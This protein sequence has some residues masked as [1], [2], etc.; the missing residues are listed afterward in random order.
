MILSKSL[1]GHGCEVIV[2]YLYECKYCGAN[3]DADEKCDCQEEE[4]KKIRY[5]ETYVQKNFVK[6][7]DGQMQIVL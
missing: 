7:K 5:I 4:Y 1:A 2:M 3:L 6:R